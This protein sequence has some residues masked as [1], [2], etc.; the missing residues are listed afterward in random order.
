MAVR[1]AFWPTANQMF[2]LSRQRGFVCQE[3]FIMQH[4]K[5]V[6]IVLPTSSDLLLSIGK[7]LEGD[8]ISLILSL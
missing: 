8:L 4:G 7:T 2:E 3:V 6:L 5:T 1:A